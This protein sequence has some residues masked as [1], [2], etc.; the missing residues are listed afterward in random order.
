M[1]NSIQNEYLKRRKNEQDIDG[2]G[3]TDTLTQL[4]TEFHKKF[5]K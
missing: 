1:Q 2:L 3:Y 4:S 5:L